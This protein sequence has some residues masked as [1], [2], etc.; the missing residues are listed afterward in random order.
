MP[1][2]PAHVVN[3]RGRRVAALDSARRGLGLAVS[4]NHVNGVLGGGNF[5]RRRKKNWAFFTPFRTIV[6]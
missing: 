5:R 1:R 4:S 2:Q 3:V 6:T